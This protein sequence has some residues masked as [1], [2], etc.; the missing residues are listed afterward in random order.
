MDF[1]MN[2]RGK[3]Y[4]AMAIMASQ[5]T[6]NPADFFETLAFIW[7]TRLLYPIKVLGLQGEG[8]TSE[9]TTPQH[10]EIASLAGK[11]SHGDQKA[12]RLLLC[13]RQGEKFA[14]SDSYSDEASPAMVGDAVV[15]PLIA[16]RIF[17]FSSNDFKDYESA[18]GVDGL[19]DSQYSIYLK[20]RAVDTWDMLIAWSSFDIQKLAESEINGPAN[21]VLLRADL[22]PQFRKFQFWFEPTEQP[23]A[24][25][26]V[27]RRNTGY[28][29]KVITFANCH[30]KPIAIPDPKILGLHAA[31]ANVLNASGAGEYI[32]SCWRDMDDIRVLSPDGA[33][34]LHSLNLALPRLVTV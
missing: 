22:D 33:T 27:A 1:A 9:D 20:K 24:Y 2:H 5:D 34:S 3:R 18:S 13:Q 8:L 16:S 4:I 12:L 17:P 23:N 19:M 28:N 31:F 30:D 29:K 6:P 25:N 10:Q 26:L 21:A 11:A 7:L 32:D 15:A 14:V